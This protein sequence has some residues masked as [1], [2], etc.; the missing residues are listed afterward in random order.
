MSNK[1]ARRVFEDITLQWQGTDYVIRS[2]RVMGAIS[3]IERVVT[4]YELLQMTAVQG[5][6]SVSAVSMAFASILRYA[7]C[8]ITDAEVYDGMW[9]GE[10]LHAKTQAA[11]EVLLRMM[12]P[13]ARQAKPAVPATAEEAAHMGEGGPIE[14]V[15]TG[16][17]SSLEPTKPL[18]SGA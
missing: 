4:L 9:E 17:R 18:E 13:P 2:D 10:E 16:T 15:K 14:P 8:D 3:R 7:G 12:V 5:A 1:K 11:V 6:P